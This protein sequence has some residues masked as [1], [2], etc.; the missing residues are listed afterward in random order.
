M[1]FFSR[2]KVTLLALL[3]FLG[4]NPCFSQNAQVYFYE[5]EVD[6]FVQLDTLWSM[7]IGAGNRGMLQERFNGE[8]ISGY[9]HD[10][11]EFN[12]FTNYRAKEAVVLSLGL[13]Y[14]F[15]EV[16]DAAETDEFRIIEQVEIEPVG[17]SLSHRFRLEQRFREN[18]IHR[19]RY[20]IAHTTPLGRNFALDIGTEAIYAIS[21][22]LKPE[23]EQRFS[24]GMENSSF[25]N[26]KLALGFEYR[27]ENYVRDLAHEFFVITGVTLDL[28]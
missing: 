5:N 28:N 11:I 12:H 21:R 6:L 8:K 22:Q 7:D 9:Q 20:D 25:Q 24:I 1:E 23:A 18:T 13:R 14:R 27:M 10:H 26:A 3:I 19:I 15:R 17:S 2:K 16:F 4:A